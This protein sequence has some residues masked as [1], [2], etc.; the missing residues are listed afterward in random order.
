MCI[1]MYIYIY[2]IIYIYIYIL[3]RVICSTTIMISVS[4]TTMM[5]PCVLLS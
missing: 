4:V 2:M 3:G 1:C 5:L